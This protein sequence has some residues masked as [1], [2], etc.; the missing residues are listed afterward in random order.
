MGSKEFLNWCEKQVKEYALEH[1]D[2]EYISD[3]KKARFLGVNGKAYRLTAKSFTKLN[4]VLKRNK[5]V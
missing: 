2:I 3:T 1:L 5:V 4:K